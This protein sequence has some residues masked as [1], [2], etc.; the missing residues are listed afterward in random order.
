MAKHVM[1]MSNNR[2]I[3]FTMMNHYLTIFTK[4]KRK[5]NAQNVLFQIL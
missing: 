3:F 5:M 2:S 1:E 4:H